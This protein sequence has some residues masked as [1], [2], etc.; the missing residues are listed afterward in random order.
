VRNDRTEA[1]IE[2][3]PRE[4]ST[5]YIYGIAWINLEDYSVTL[6]Q[7]NPR[8]IRGYELLQTLAKRLKTKLYLSL[9]AEFDHIH[10]GIRF[11]TRVSMR[12]KYRGGRNVSR[13]SH[14]KN[15]ERNHT[16]FTYSNYQF[17]DI[18]VDVIEEKMK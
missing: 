5:A 12:E 8:S 1:V 16:E 10:N 14:S 4:P 7:A 18:T 13:Y 2:V 9:E 11:P 3:I 15:W 17:F 6:I